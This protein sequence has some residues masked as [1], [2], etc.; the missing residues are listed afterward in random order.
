MSIPIVSHV[1]IC[2]ELT[3]DGQPTRMIKIIE[4]FDKQSTSKANK[5]PIE[6][7]IPPIRSSGPNYF[8]RLPDELLDR[9]INFAGISNNLSAA[10]SMDPYEAGWKDE[11]ELIQWVLVF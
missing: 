9:I 3:E 4:I 11:E 10:I 8:A 7:P 5:Q 2:E 1:E 6:A